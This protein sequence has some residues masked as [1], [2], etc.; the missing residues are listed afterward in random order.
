MKSFCFCFLFFV[1]LST[2][3]AKCQVPSKNTSWKLEELFDRLVGNYNDSVRIQ[4]NDSV[5]TILDVYVKSDTVFTHRFTNL[6]YLGQIMSPDSLLK[7]ITWNLVLENEP[8]RYFCYFIRKQ[9][10]GKNNKIYRLSTNY[11]EKQVRT[12][13]TYTE[14]DWYGALYYDLKPIIVNNKRFWV[15]LGIDYGNYS[16][17]RKIIEV[18]NFTA[19]GSIVFGNRWFAS[20][21][22]TKYRDVFEYAS[23]AMMS[24]RFRSD[25]S[26]VFD[27]LVPFSD[28]HKDDRQYY[29][30]DYSFDAYNFEK[31]L[32][33]LII[34]VDA[35]NK[36]Q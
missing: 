20:G 26:I 11:N 2:G 22:Q 17:S 3:V 8:G 29:G 24:L 15:M 28:S 30:P 21:E 32:W 10:P 4:I 9:E 12:D 19:D 35:R 13:T 25:S 7:I 18:L 33:R 31:G 27:H 16:T 23:N 36:E 1:L 6:R 14:M 34:N 5:R